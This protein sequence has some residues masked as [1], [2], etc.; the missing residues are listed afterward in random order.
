MSEFKLIIAG[1][2]D[3]DDYWLLH[4]VI[5]ALSDDPAFDGK[6]ISIVSGM[7]RGADALGYMFAHKNNIQVYEYPANWPKYGKRAGYVRNE[8]MGQF[9]DGLVAFWDKQSRGTAH[10]I[11]FMHKQNKPVYVVEFERN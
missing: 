6:D 3:F 9:A 2:R 10:M 4:R 1:S 11:Q 5:Y 8:A 7:A